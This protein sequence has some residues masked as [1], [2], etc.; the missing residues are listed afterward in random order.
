[1]LS[2]HEG[3]ARSDLASLGYVL[4]ELLSGAPPFA[5]LKG[6]G[7]LQQAKN[8]IV[9]RLPEILP[10]EVVRNELLMSLITGLIAPDPA[11]RFPDARAADLVEEGAASFQR[12][13]V[14]G[15]LSSEYAN[16]IRV[17]LEE[18]EDAPDADRP[19]NA[20]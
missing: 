15:D 9:D 17:W 19:G 14:K 11:D 13:L 7:E 5:G 2:G 4:V 6:L 10:E 12:Q 18:L 3:S 16:E 8:S 20:A 1:V